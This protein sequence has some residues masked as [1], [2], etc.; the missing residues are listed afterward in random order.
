MT[1]ESDPNMSHLARSWR[2]HRPRAWRRLE[3]PVLV[4]VAPPDELRLRTARKT[5]ANF[6][7]LWR[8]PHV[9]DRLREEAVHELFVR[10]DIEGP[11]LVAAHPV[12]NEN[13][14]LLGQA[15]LKAGLLPMP[16]VMEWSGREDSSRP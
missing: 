12:P 15:L 14:W 3:R 4:Q 2:R 8:D 7:T 5:L 6:G 10:F 13:A 1:I 16:K 11:E 9:P